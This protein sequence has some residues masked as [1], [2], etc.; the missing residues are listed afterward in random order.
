[1]TLTAILTLATAV[2]AL[3][4]KPGAGMMMVMSRSMA[5]GLSACLTFVLG[6]CIVSIFF[7]LV[8][9]F[10]FKYASV[11]M[12][13]L[14]ILIKSLASVYLIW[15]GIKG[16]QGNHEG[17]SV[18]EVGARN[19]FDNLTASIVLTLSNPLTILFYAGIIPTIL[20]V[21]AMTWENIFIASLV[22]IV[23]ETFTALAYSSPLIF[24]R[25]KIK[26]D[27]L[28]GMRVFSSIVIIIVGLYI[29]YTAIP[30]K[31]LLTIF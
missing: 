2:F 5:Q 14:S 20:D 19:F 31:E 25:S 28:D 6:I 27:F 30:A 22:I 10:G 23:V 17:L 29:G 24:F 13:F 3:A 8:V 21:N 18:D 11:D 4:I 12:V 16:L 7:L 15:L 9:V 1:M 26:P